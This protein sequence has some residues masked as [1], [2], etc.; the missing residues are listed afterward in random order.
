MK[1]GQI[2]TEK[3]IRIFS[4]KRKHIDEHANLDGKKDQLRKNE[5]ERAGG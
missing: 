2:I 1:H 5:G 3:C 4:F